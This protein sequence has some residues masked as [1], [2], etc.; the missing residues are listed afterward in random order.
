[1]SI[2]RTGENHSPDQ[3]RA[4]GVIEIAMG[5][6][7]GLM[8]SM[9]PMFSCAA[10][11]LRFLAALAVCFSSAAR[12]QGQV[13]EPLVAQEDDQF[14]GGKW[15]WAAETREKQTCRFWRSFEIPRGSKVGSA[16][17]RIGVD[18]GYRLML[19]G[20]ELGAGSDW[21]SLT[22]YDVTQLLEPGRHVLAVDAFNDNREAGMMFVLV[23]ELTDGRV[24]RVPSYGR[25]RIAREGEDGWQT[26]GK[27]PAHWGSAVEVGSRVMHGGRMMERKP[28]MLVKVPPLQAVEKRFWQ[29]AWFQLGLWITVCVT[30][31]MY[32][33]VLAKLTVQS[34]A[35]AM[36]RTERA[37]IARDI[38]DELG[39]R[40]TELALEGEVIRTELPEGS[41]VRPKLQALCEKAREVSGAM[42][43][44]VWMV[45][46]RRDTLRDF[47]NFACK[48]VQRF[49]SSTPMRC[50]LDIGAD[51]PEMMLE[52]PVRRNLLLGVKEALN[53]AVKH[54]GAGEVTFRIRRAGS[55]I[56]VSVEDDG[57][58]FDLDAAD[59]TR[60]GL[61]GMIERMK[62]LGGSGR[63][64][65][66]PGAGCRVEFNI[67]HMKGGV[68]A[69]AEEP[70]VLRAAGKED[71]S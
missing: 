70:R 26:K 64:H 56:L 25:W 7:I 19:D 15:I 37:R 51:L 6:K 27:A 33:R 71:V 63:I 53:N 2:T 47:S 13:A 58:G 36:L 31:L 12:V 14:A 29:Q 44:V 61:A 32:L 62:E 23:V 10:S 54:S 34:K 69:F 42:D 67:P 43:E 48:H 55:S 24:I 52:L 16:R 5:E 28:T 4:L 17:L 22:Q 1:M 46:S 38:H 59:A 65:T 45:N 30:A 50:R 40:L 60:H 3:M 39:A 57:A 49:L 21:R 35:Q 8:V 18:N 66:A 11:I 9:N 41:A 20:R 68:A